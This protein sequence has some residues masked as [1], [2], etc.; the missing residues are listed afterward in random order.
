MAKI[1]HY[2]GQCI[3]CN[4]CVEYAPEQW[5]IAQNDGKAALK[6]AEKKKEVYVLEINAFDLQK[7]KEAAKA[8]PMRI[9][10]V[11]E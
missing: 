5:E 9:I 6:G 4:V 10:K 7:N 11:M 3:G 1:I 2:R 8:C